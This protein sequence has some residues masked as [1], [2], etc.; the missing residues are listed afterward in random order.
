[1]DR[2]KV[3]D[4]LLQQLHSAHERFHASKESL[5]KA[6]ADSEYD[7][8]QHV[9]ERM[10]EVQKIE[11]EVEDLNEKVQEILRRKV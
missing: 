2:L 7:H 8:R 4:E 11:Q 3:P 5:E 9:A 10:A 6:M 1:M